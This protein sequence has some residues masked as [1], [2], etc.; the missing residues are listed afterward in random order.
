MTTSTLRLALVS[1]LGLASLLVAPR[2]TLADYNDNN[3]DP[4][5]GWVLTVEIIPIDNL[6]LVDTCGTD[7]Q[8]DLTG[9][10][11]ITTKTLIE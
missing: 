2:S 1:G 11:T 5:D 8:V 9:T 3:F 10:A 4:E 7:S 6:G